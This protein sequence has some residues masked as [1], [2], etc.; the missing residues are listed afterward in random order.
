M[1][2]FCRG[3]RTDRAWITYALS[4]NV[5]DMKINGLSNYQ[6]EVVENSPGIKLGTASGT[7]I[8]FVDSSWFNIGKAYLSA[9]HIK[10]IHLI[11]VNTQ[12][13]PLL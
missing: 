6:Q 13:R 8:T 12:D 3:Q 1:G 10:Y 11:M 4:H 9:R 5:K 7:Y 2:H